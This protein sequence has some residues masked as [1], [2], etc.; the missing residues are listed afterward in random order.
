MC[1]H[2]LI[3]VVKLYYPPRPSHRSLSLDSHFFY[4][5]FFQG[6]HKVLGLGMKRSTEGKNKNTEFTDIKISDSMSF[7]S[8]SLEKAVE[9]MVAGEE[10]RLKN[11]FKMCVHEKK[12]NIQLQTGQKLESCSDCASRL[13]LEAEENC[14]LNM[15]RSSCVVKDRNEEFSLELYQLA[16]AK[17]NIVTIIC[18]YFF[19]GVFPYSALDKFEE[20]EKD[21][22]PFEEQDFYKDLGT[23]QNV[24]KAD[25]ETFQ[26]A[27]ETLKRLKYT[28]MTRA[29]YLR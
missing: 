29:K 15:I 17:G 3:V 6:P 19:S 12:T 22:R 5:F 1:S 7:I 26:H 2:W 28:D 23:E 27:W 10:N 14:A 18:I 8:A 16:T 25:Y 11:I 9:K 4:F 24:S 20:F 13:K 21:T